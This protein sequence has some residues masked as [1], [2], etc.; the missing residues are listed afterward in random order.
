MGYTGI[1]VYYLRKFRF[2]GLFG[3]AIVGADALIRPLGNVPN[4]I[5]PV[6]YAD[7][8][9]LGKGGFG[10]VHFEGEMYRTKRTDCHGL[11]R[12]PRNDTVYDSAN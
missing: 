8:P 3:G 5:P 4:N 12:K 11:L 9:P 1:I 2:V 6:S 7:F 10:A